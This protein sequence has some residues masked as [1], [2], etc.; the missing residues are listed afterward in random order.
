[1]RA[2]GGP[3]SPAV[4]EAI[5]LLMPSGWRKALGKN[6]LSEMPVIMYAIT[7]SST[8]QLTKGVF[9]RFESKIFFKSVIN[10]PDLLT[11]R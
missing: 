10:C 4:A 9:D 11:L 2:R 7:F 1:M 5:G 8:T 3:C 6:Q